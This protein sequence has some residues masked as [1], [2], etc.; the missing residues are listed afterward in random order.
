VKRLQYPGLASVYGGAIATQK[1]E[2]ELIPEMATYEV[3][4]TLQ[5]SMPLNRQQFGMVSLAIE[6]TSFLVD[7]LRYLYGVFIRESGF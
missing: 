5:G 3:H 4:L 2:D 7:G 6:P 1:L